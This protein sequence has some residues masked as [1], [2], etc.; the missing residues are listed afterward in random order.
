MRKEAAATHTQNCN[1]VCLALPQERKIHKESNRHITESQFH[2]VKYEHEE[3]VITSQLWQ[4]N[5][6]TLLTLILLCIQ[7]RIA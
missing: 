6:E 7:L 5:L 1:L 2:I 4:I 3:S